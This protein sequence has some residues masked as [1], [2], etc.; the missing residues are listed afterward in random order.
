MVSGQAA[1]A[2]N[3]APQP[4]AGDVMHGA[5]RRFRTAFQFQLPASRP[6]ARAINRARRVRARL[7]LKILPMWT[8]WNCTSSQICVHLHPVGPTVQVR[9]FMRSIVT[10]YF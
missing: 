4:S 7:F 9:H 10:A 6:S 3:N 2:G 8:A 1:T 5:V